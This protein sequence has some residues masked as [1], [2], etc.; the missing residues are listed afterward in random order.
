MF[1][2]IRIDALFLFRLVIHLRPSLNNVVTTLDRTLNVV[3]HDRLRYLRDRHL[4]NHNSVL[5]LTVHPRYSREICI[6]ALFYL[7]NADYNFAVAL[8]K[9]SVF[10]LEIKVLIDKSLSSR[11]F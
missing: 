5:L 6:E 7:L 9:L 10:S 11:L 3:L 2:G 1:L 4:E 8:T